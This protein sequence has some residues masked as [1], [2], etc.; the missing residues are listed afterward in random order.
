M[1][2]H[3]RE[4]YTIITIRINIYGW[5][6]YIENKIIYQQ[7]KLIKTMIKIEKVENNGYFLYGLDSVSN[8]VQFG[9][10]IG[11]PTIDLTI[12]FK[13]HLV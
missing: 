5:L 12:N 13:I 1:F 10:Q 4:F 6:G 9:N 7:R 8:L 2:V 11:H 3:D